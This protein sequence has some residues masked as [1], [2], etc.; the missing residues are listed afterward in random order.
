MTE[1]SKPK[2]RVLY[3]DGNS[4]YA[5]AVFEAQQE[6]VDFMKRHHDSH[7]VRFKVYVKNSPQFCDTLEEAREIAEK[8]KESF[9]PVFPGNGFPSEAITLVYGL[10]NCHPEGGDLHAAQ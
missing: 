2:Y 9:K 3:L 8:H 10:A 4:K 6:M 1:K 7:L 5:I